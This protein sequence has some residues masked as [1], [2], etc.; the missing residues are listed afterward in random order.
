M[1]N[2]TKASSAYATKSQLFDY[3]TKR[4]FNEFKEE[5]YHFRDDMTDFKASTDKRFISV[6][7]KLDEIREEFRIQTGIILD[8]FKEE[9]KIM[10]EYVSPLF[11]LLEKTEA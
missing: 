6:D 2:K 9:R 8:Q 5:M 11:R 7:R 1:T 10:M 3:V 4:E